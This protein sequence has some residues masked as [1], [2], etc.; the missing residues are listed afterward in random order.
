MRRAGEGKL[1]NFEQRF[2]SPSQRSS[3]SVPCALVA[4][5]PESQPVFG[6]CERADENSFAQDLFKDGTRVGMSGQSIELRSA[7]DS[8]ARAVQ[9]S[10]ETLRFLVQARTRRLE[11]VRI[12]E[13]ADPDCNRWPADGPRS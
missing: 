5:D 10:V 3:E 12:S 11:P 7:D 4:R 1:T 8:P 9:E 2:G 13:R 6:L